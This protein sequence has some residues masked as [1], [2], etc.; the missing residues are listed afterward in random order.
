M[1]KYARVTQYTLTRPVGHSCKESRKDLSHKYMN[2]HCSGTFWNVLD[3]VK[4]G[5]RGSHSYKCGQ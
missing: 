1:H 5:L 3:A 4:G 2:T